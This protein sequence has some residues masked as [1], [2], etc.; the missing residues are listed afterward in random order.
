L[1]DPVHHLLTKG[2]AEP[3]VIWTPR[4]KTPILSGVDR[5]MRIADVVPTVHCSPSVIEDRLLWLLRV[6]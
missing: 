4:A 6:F 1:K 3:P 5:G 2:G